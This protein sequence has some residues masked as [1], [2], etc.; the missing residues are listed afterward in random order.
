VLRNW[1]SLLLLCFYVIILVS[2]H[3]LRDSEAAV[4]SKDATL[5]IKD[6]ALA[7]ANT[8]IAALQLE[9]SNEQSK[10]K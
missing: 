9:L 8:K 2:Q 3:R 10:Y 5:A 6:E 7:T 1:Y 4:A